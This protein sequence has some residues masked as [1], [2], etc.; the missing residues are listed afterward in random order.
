MRAAGLWSVVAVVM[1]MGVVGG[2]EPAAGR[3]GE[4]GEGETEPSCPVDVG[5]GFTATL[6]LLQSPDERAVR[7]IVASGA[8]GAL[9]VSS[10]ELDALASFAVSIPGVA[11][12]T[13]P[14]G[15]SVDI[16][17][18]ED[19]CSEGT[20]P[21]LRIDVDGALWVAFSTCGSLIGSC[22][23]IGLA[24][25]VAPVCAIGELPECGCVE[26][27]ARFTAAL[28]DSGS[29]DVTTGQAATSPDGAFAVA[30]SEDFTVVACS[31]DDYAALPGSMLLA[32]TATPATGEGE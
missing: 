29:F 30:L 27:P 1:G 20:Q 2:C 11:L 6:D 16:L 23:D 17:V 5:P 14:V 3:E 4:G 32:A 25:S 24:G 12:A 8:P 18:C 19:G 22:V 26:R 7:G 21:S 31:C 15:A 9:V 13:P 28:D 10:T